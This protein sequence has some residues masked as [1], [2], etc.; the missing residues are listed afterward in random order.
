MA[1]HLRRCS[2][3]DNIVLDGSGAH[4][5]SRRGGRG[6]VHPRRPQQPV[7][8]CPR[9]AAMRDQLAHRYFH[10]VHAIVGQIRGAD[11]T[12]LLAANQSLLSVLDPRD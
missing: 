2:L 4:H 5:P 1:E 12:G 3:S 6:T 8:L 10:T 11:L 7:V 9:V